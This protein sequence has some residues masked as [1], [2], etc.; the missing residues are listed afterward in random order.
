MVP[1]AADGGSTAAFKARLQQKVVRKLGFQW[2]KGISSH[3]AAAACQQ[4]VCALNT[5]T[6]S[7]GVRC[8]PSFMCCCASHVW[9]I[10]A[11]ARSQNAKPSDLLPW[12]VE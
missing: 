11:A 10:T 2:V 1:E 5:Y 6:K 4:A 8:P 12:C 3:I 7:Q 9:F